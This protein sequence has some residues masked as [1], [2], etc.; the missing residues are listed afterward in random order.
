LEIEQ[1]FGIE[2]SKTAENRYL[3]ACSNIASKF[4]VAIHMPWGLSRSHCAESGGLKDKLRRR[5]RQV[6]VR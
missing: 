4:W 3:G 1:V 5:F 2:R 6:E